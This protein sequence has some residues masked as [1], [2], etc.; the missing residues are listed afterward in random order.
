MYIVA[1][2]IYDD[3]DS[4]AIDIDFGD[5]CRSCRVNIYEKSE[6]GKLETVIREA[7]VDMSTAY[8]ERRPMFVY[9]CKNN[10]VIIK[11][12]HNFAIDYNMSEP[13]M[14]VLLRDGVP[15]IIISKPVKIINKE[16]QVISGYP[17][18]IYEIVYSR[19]FKQK[20]ESAKK[21]FQIEN[22]I[23]VRDSLSYLDAQLELVTELV[24]GIIDCLGE[25]EKAHMAEKNIFMAEFVEVQKSTSLL[26]FKTINKC[27]AELKGHKSMLRR[28]QAEYY[29]SRIVK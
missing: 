12:N 14:S 16:Y 25:A 7:Y 22:N 4:N 13:I 20:F 29:K 23:Q 3:N 17:K 24:L 26:K 10:E 6:S 18:E 5:D 27:L 1:N 9:V 11:P 8:V 15:C 28:L 21:R 2:K 19:D